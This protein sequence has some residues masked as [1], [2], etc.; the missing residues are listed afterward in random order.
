MLLQ[1]EALSLGLRGDVVRDVNCAKA[2]AMAKAMPGDLVYI[3]GSTYVV[4]E[5][6]EL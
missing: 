2:A 1:K 5:I 6:A 3:G 4:A